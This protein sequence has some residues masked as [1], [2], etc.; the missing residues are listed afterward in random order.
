MVNN[1]QFIENGSILPRHND[2]GELA[3]TRFNPGFVDDES[4]MAT[5]NK[6]VYNEIESDDDGSYDSLEPG[7]TALKRG[8]VVTRF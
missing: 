2:N 5:N 3:R 1:H 7:E 6:T 4:E 8:V